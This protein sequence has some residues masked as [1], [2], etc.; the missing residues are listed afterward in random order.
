MKKQLFALSMLVLVGCTQGTTPSS[1]ENNVDGSITP[2]PAANRT[3]DLSNTIGNGGQI[4][5]PETKKMKV[6]HPNNLLPIYEV[7][8][9]VCGNLSEAKDGEDC[10]SKK[11]GEVL[12]G[13]VSEPKLIHSLGLYDVVIKSGGCI[14][15]YKTPQPP[16]YRMAGM[17]F[18][19]RNK[20]GPKPIVKMTRKQM[21][22][23]TLANYVDA[24]NATADSS[25]S[26]MTE[27]TC[28]ST[29]WVK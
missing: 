20:D 8:L 16:V 11:E 21:T 12:W 15:F 22:E 24:Y 2:R 9:Q 4:Q 7:K 25:L 28:K 19:V 5:T 18:T 27:D 13:E 10:I 3:E 26:M 1:S 23:Q 6:E 29:P 17:S 14:P